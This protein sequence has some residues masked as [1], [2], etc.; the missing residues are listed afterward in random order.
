MTEPSKFTTNGLLFAVIIALLLQPVAALD[1]SNQNAPMLGEEIEISPTGGRSA[2][3]EWVA[4]AVQASGA[5][6]QSPNLVF[7]SDILVDS[8]DNVITV[9]NLVADITFG[10]LG[11]S[12]QY[13]LGFVALANSQGAW[14]WVEVLGT[15]DGGGYAG[16]TAITEVGSDYYMCGWFQGNITFGNQ[17]Y[18]STQDTQDIFVSKISSTGQFDWTITAGGPFTDTCEDIT[19]DSGG[20]VYA[21]GS[22]NTTANFQSTAKTSQGGLDGWFSKINTGQ[23]TTGNRWS[24]ITTVGGSTDDYGTCVESNGNN[25]YGCGWFT[26]TANFGTGQPVQ[27]IGQ[28]DS[29]VL[30][31]STSG[32][33]VDMAQAG[34]T[35]GIVQIMDM[36]EAAGTIHAT[37]Q[38]I[39]SANFGTNQATSSNGG[40]DRT[41]FVA[42]LGTN[43]LWSWATMASGA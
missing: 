40:Q 35:G 1:F 29:Y 21:A 5:N 2:Q 31:M 37:G 13:Q 11:A 15:Y 32:S 26:G 30:K 16:V 3:T 24:W 17:N 6:T 39:G 10:T 22:F 28:L 23:V 8:N 25:V 12:T 9:G 20:G 36:V 41:V 7:P 38:L 34:A 27:A 14:Q 19:S 33:T 43:N 42:S 4:S 18:R